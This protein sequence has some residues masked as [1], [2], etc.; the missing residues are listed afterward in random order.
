MKL[1][2]MSLSN[3]TNLVSVFHVLTNRATHSLSMGVLQ[4]DEPG[5]GVVE[6]P[7]RAPDGGD[8]PV[9][10]HGAVGV[11]G[12]GP[13]VDAAEGGDAAVLVDVDVGVVAEDDLAAPG[14]AVREDGDEVGHG[15]RG[16]EQ[17]GLLAHDPRHLR[18]EAAGRRVGA[19]HVVVHVRRD[20][21]GP[22]GLRRLGHRV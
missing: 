4:A 19:Q 9:D 11:V 10:V 18:L 21:G 12:D 16:D 2:A 8:D 22:H 1:Q 5:G 15:A 6:R 13:G 14:V 20:H 3:F 7:V 17:R